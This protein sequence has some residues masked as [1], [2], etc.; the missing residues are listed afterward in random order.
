MGATAEYKEK[1]SLWSSQKTRQLENLVKSLKH[2][3]RLMIQQ[4]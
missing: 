3:D 1:E 4:V 2:D